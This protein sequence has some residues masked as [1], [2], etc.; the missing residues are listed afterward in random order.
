VWYAVGGAL[1][2][3]SVEGPH[4][5]KASHVQE[6]DR[7]RN[8]T[9]NELWNITTSLNVFNVSM[10][11]TDID[12]QIFIFQSN[13]VHKIREEGYDGTLASQWTFSGSF[14]FALTVI[15][16]IGE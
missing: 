14:L 5:D 8:K 2:F 11:E 4:E 7:F 16:T 13:L 15:T 10:W 12:A 6:F 9:L 1:L 3:Q